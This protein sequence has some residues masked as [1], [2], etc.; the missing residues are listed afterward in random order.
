MVMLL[1]RTCDKAERTEVGGVRYETNQDTHLLKLT[2]KTHWTKHTL[3]VTSMKATMSALG[4][5]PT[6]FI[7]D[8]AIRRS[9]LRSEVSGTKQITHPLQL[10]HKKKHTLLACVTS[11]FFFWQGRLVHMPMNGFSWAVRTLERPHLSGCV[12]TGN[13]LS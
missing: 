8:L 6:A 3:P 12:S 9:A 2:K 13:A 4:E 5:C 1:C 11:V 10:T 7:F